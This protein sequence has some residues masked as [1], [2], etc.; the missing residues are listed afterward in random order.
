MET[1]N[2]ELIKGN[3]YSKEEIESYGCKYIKETTITMFYR[4]GDT[5]YIFDTKCTNQEEKHKLLTI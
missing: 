2:S 5:L 3:C 4:K 1:L